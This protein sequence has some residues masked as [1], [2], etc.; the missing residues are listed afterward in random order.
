MI[1]RTIITK[2][3]PISVLLF[4][5]G[6]AC[7]DQNSNK[8][9]FPENDVVEA[10]KATQAITNQDTLLVA[11]TYWWPEAGPFIGNCPQPYSLAFIGTVSNIE[12]PKAKNTEQPYISQWGTVSIDE[13]LDKRTLENEHY[14][15]EAYVAFDCFSEANLTQDDRVLVFIYEYEGGY[16]IPG[17]KSMLK[18]SGENDPKVASIKTFIASNYDPLVI[19]K[20]LNLW[21]TAGQGDALKQFID[22]KRS[23]Q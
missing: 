19:E 20:D 10:I 21:Q 13:I 18:I 16:V 1:N 12:E 2:L 23:M 17:N 9:Q 15:E 22:C 5:L 8:I 6:T 14:H 11:Y 3:L 4:L 7:K